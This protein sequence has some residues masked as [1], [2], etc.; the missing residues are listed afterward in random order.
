MEHY[1]VVST[2]IP[3]P[4]LHC[5]VR[6]V[7]DTDDLCCIVWLGGSE[8]SLTESQTVAVGSVSASFS[9]NILELEYFLQNDGPKTKTN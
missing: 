3:I 4:G 6:R 1:S 5:F 7:Y 2:I 9:K 8:V